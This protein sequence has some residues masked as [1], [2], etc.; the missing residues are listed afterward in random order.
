[1][2]SVDTNLFS[3]PADLLS[4]QSLR[5]EED[6]EARAIYSVAKSDAINQ[7]L[8]EYRQRPKEMNERIALC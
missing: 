8:S 6:E 3:S 7:P 5:E 1:M 4:I 2:E